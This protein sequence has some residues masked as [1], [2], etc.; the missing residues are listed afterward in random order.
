M[1]EG[2]STCVSEGERE[3]SAVFVNG[4]LSGGDYLSTLAKAALTKVTFSSMKKT[5]GH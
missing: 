4:M 2:G 3:A 1:S 5:E